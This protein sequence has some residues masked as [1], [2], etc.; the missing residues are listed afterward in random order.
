MDNFSIVFNPL[1]A[2]GPISIAVYHIV[3]VV[4]LVFG[5]PVTVRILSKILSRYKKMSPNW[6]RIIVLI[7]FLVKALLAVV[8]LSII[9]FSVGINVN[10]V[11]DFSIINTKHINI[12]II[13]ILMLLLAVLLTRIVLFFIKEHFN[14]IIQKDPKQKGKWNALFQIFSYL[15]WIIVC[16]LVLETIGVKVTFLIASSA[17]LLVGLGLGLQNIFNDIVSGVVLLLERTLSVDDVIEVE[18]TIGRVK[19]IGLRSSTIVS[20]DDIIIIIPNSNLTSDKVINWSHIETRT[21]FRIEVGVAYGSDVRKVETILLECA[22]SHEEIAKYPKPFVRFNDFG[23]SS[24]DFQ[25]FFWTYKAFTV[26]NIKSDLRFLID[27]AFRKHSITIPFPQR[28]IHI[29]NV[30]PVY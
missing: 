22:D 21:R 17:A 12:S 24:L 8:S 9:L 4:F 29:K 1:I 11:L 6:E 5:I 15:V 10:S 7:L 30:N 18:G 14:N 3:L 19:E 26:E 28:D 23:N 20:R 16:A 27:D 25:L 2:L 13:S